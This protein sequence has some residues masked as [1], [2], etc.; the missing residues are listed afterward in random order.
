MIDC[1]ITALVFGGSTALIF[2]G[3]LAF[4]HWIKT[5]RDA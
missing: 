5:R 2:W 4:I 3:I 1:I